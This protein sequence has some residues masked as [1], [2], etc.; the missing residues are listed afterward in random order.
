MRIS[1][2]FP[3]SEGLSNGE[4]NKGRHCVQRNS[5]RGQPW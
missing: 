1:A 5:Q 2:A 4:M 3:N